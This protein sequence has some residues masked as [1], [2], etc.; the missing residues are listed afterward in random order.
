[1]YFI[2]LLFSLH[3]PLSSQLNS[4][5]PFSFI[6]LNISF[7]QI[8]LGWPFHPLSRGI[9]SQTCQGNFVSG[10]LC[11]WPYHILVAYISHSPS[12]KKFW[13]FISYLMTVFI[14][15]VQFRLSSGSSKTIH[16]S[17]KQFQ[18]ELL[19][20]LLGFSTIYW[21]TLNHGFINL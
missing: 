20:L 13:T 18:T 19:V 17:R 8:L 21:C 15:F 12:I 14:Y 4:S 5:N 10:I 1:M 7:I 16:F 9:Q 3:L 2:L 11:T 6:F